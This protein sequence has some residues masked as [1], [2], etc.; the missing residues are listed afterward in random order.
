M[1]NKFDNDMYNTIRRNI[2]R[3]RLQRNM[4]AMQ[5]ADLVEM[6]HDY[7]RQIESEKIARNCSVDMLY[8]IAVALNITMNDLFEKHEDEHDENQVTLIEKNEDNM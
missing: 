4:T 5:L 7:L 8:R 1:T 2:K 6:S 3:Y